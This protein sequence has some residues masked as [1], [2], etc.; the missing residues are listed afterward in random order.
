[1]RPVTT[2][3]FVLTLAGVA[4]CGPETAPRAGPAASQVVT[5]TDENFEELVLGSDRPVLV[6]FWAAWCRPCLDMKPAVR[7]IAAE[8]RGR[9]VVGELDA[10]ANAFT[11]GK[12]GVRSFPT[13]LL[14]RD[15]R[16]VARLEGPKTTEEL[17]RA[18]ENAGRGIRRHSG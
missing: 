16:P 17:A 8:F 6:D 10:E 15:G 9:A 12:Y 18:L 14:F 2:A 1:M 7:E 13:L 4:G 3:A 11:A 5:L